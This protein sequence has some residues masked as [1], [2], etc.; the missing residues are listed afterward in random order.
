[1][2]H[3]EAPERAAL[4]PLEHR[5]PALLAWVTAR[6]SAM[7]RAGR[8]TEQRLRSV[9]RNLT[10]LNEA[11]GGCER[12]VQTPVPFAYAQH[13]KVLVTLFCYSAPFV[14]A[15][16]MGWATPLAVG[17]LAFALMGIDEI[18]VEIEDPFGYDPND[19]PLE[20]IGELVEKTSA[21]V[22]AGAPSTPPVSRVA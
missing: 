17:F 7:V 21:D 19:L 4:E 14:F 1:M 18:G 16:Q 20:A 8:L 11:L 9:D 13:I 3:L 22:L 15:E 10:L 2:A 5:A 12:I 6:F